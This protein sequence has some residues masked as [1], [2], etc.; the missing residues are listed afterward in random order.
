MKT[1][2][3]YE[4]YFNSTM[5]PK[6]DVYVA[7]YEKYRPRYWKHMR[8]FLLLALAMAFLAG[9][10]NQAHPEWENK[11]GVL[12]MISFILALF[13][14]PL[15]RAVNFHLKGSKVMKVVKE[16]V[17]IP[18]YGFLAPEMKYT[19]NKFVNPAL[20]QESRIFNHYDSLSGEDFFS[21][22]EGS[23]YLEFSELVVH[24]SVPVSTKNGT[25]WESR[26][27]NG[28]FLVADFNKN[29]DGFTLLYPDYLEKTMGDQGARWANTA[30]K[31]ANA[32][33]Q[34]SGGNRKLFHT[35]GLA[36][37]HDV[38]MEDPE[39]EE[40]FKVQCSD[41]V[42]AHYILSASFMKR[43][44]DFSQQVKTPMYLSFANSQMCLYMES[45]RGGGMFDISMADNPGEFESYKDIYNDLDLAL[46][47]V[48]DLNL[49]LRIWNKGG[50]ENK[51][52]TP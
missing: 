47:L 29:F 14:V 39:F 28:L 35:G 12:P 16:Q 5:K 34:R 30:F 40:N 45:R 51:I 8:W 7:K 52:G 36:G 10:A 50:M 49:N 48:E 42:E 9:W 38:H 11:L 1:L 44:T 21:G 27:N 2:E 24:Y 22:H 31:V 13:V 17:V 6:L 4:A 3:E 20:V 37:L 46:G 15:W 19:Q 26:T 41:D 23:T 25:R 18:L 43:L 32:I 33:N